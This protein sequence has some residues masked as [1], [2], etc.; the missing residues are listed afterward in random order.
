MQKILIVDDEP[1]ICFAMREYFAVHGYKVDCAQKVDEIRPIL[2]RDCYA[3]VIADLRLAGVHNMGGLEVVK[4]VREKSPATR[5]L[6][7][8]AFGSPEVEE[9]ARGYGADA[10]L[11]KPKPL[12]EVAQIVFGLIGSAR[13][14][15][16]VL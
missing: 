16:K 5:I 7:L 9:E 11:H 12:A 2:A 1:S 8:T 10:F 13:P 15:S 4:L 3:V 6:V 14:I